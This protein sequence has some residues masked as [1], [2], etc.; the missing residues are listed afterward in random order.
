MITAVVGA[1]GKTTLIHKLAKEYLDMGRTVCVITTT[2]MFIEDDTLLTDDPDVILEHIQKHG[3]AMA[4]IQEGAKITALSEPTYQK[5]CNSVDEILIEA[6]GSKHLP[7]KYP[8]A[9]EP[10]IPSNVDHVIIVCG[11]AALGHKAKDVVF[12]L[13][14]ASKVLD[15]KETD[16]VTPWH[17]QTL[18]QKGYVNN[19]MI[20]T[21]DLSIH[22][23]H[24]NTLYQRTVAVLLESQMDVSIIKEK[25]FSEKP[26]LFICGGGHVAKQVADIASMLDFRIKVIDS[27]KELANKERF[28][29][30]QEVICDDFTNLENYLETDSF[31]VVVTPGHADDYTCVST[32]LKTPY[33]YLGMIGSHRKVAKTFDDL[34]SVGFTDEQIATIHAPIGLKIG[35][36]TPGEIAISILA[37][38]IQIKNADYAASVSKELLTSTEHGVLCIIIDKTGST[39]RGNGSMMLVTPNGQID[40]I[41]GGAIE[42]AAIQD[43]RNITAP[44]IKEYHLNEE[45]KTLGMICGGTNKILF[46]PV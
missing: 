16:I 35:A 31:Y 32:I 1:G 36:N 11:L 12:R 30:A 27:R 3:Y 5:L 19:P 37:E 9:T 42:N 18:I 15:I 7:V 29:Y 20:S 13:N 33:Q 43:A 22:A 17:I 14:E 26:C 6:D 41:G 4:G 23:V 46:V 8:K 10:V 21:K 28:P 24:D 38:I 34:R 2:H 45:D 40:T 39:P 25:W 44:T